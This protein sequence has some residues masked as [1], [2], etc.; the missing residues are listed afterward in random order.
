[1]GD[2]SMKRLLLPLLLFSLQITSS[3]SGEY[4]KKL[5]L[6]DAAPAWKELPGIDDKKHSLSDLKDK[7][8][9]V[10]IFTCNSCPIA[11]DYED[12]IVAFTKKNANEKVGIVAI[13]VNTIP[14]DR[15]PAMKKR[16]EAKKFTFPYLYD[17]TQQIAKDFGA[18]F[19]PEFFVLDKNRKVIYMGAM[20]D[21]STAEKVKEN[22]LQA[23]VDATLKGE[24]PSQG[25]TLG[26]GCQIRF[27]RARD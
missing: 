8:V 24:K 19:T 1:M 10:V 26:R 23:A 4:N 6:G 12:R 15:L 22:Y 18:R 21:T 16:A 25:E 20:D 27:K 11:E 7:E 2:P 9:V 14:E 3:H 13:N 5:N 17:E